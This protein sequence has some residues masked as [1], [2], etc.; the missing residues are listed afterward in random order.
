MVSL[1]LQ[2]SATIFVL[3]YLWSTY[4]PSGDKGNEDS[5]EIP[6]HPMSRLSRQQV[7]F[8]HLVELT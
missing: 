1:P 7:P 6:D 3:V 5:G 2:A 4:K 8:A